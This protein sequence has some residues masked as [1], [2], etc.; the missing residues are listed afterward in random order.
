MRIAYAFKYYGIDSLCYSCYNRIVK[1]DKLIFNKDAI[2]DKHKNLGLKTLGGEIET[3][4]IFE[5]FE[6]E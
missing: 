5:E 3:V 2:I 4:L 1:G 6:S